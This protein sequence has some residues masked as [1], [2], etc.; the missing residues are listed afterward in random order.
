M[1]VEGGDKTPAKKAPIAS[2]KRLQMNADDCNEHDERRVKLHDALA[3]LGSVDQRRNLNRMAYILVFFASSCFAVL[4]F[5]IISDLLLWEG[6]KETVARLLIAI[7]WILIIP[8]WILTFL[9]VISMLDSMG[10]RSVA[11]QR[12]SGLTLSLDELHE[13]RDLLVDREWKHGRIFKSVITD[14]AKKQTRAGSDKPVA[15]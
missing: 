13:L 15:D 5:F 12:L 11:R 8:I 2:G 6:V 1:A 7:S 9:L 14:L 10:I 4:A 3:I